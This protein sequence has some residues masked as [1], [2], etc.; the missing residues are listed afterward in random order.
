M[1]RELHDPTVVRQRL[2][3]EKECG[4][5]ASQNSN[6]VNNDTWNTRTR[7]NLCNKLHVI[8]ILYCFTNSMNFDSSAIS[9][10][11]ICLKLYN[12]SVTIY[13]CEL[14]P[15]TFI[16]MFWFAVSDDVCFT[17]YFE[18]TLLTFNNLPIVLVYDRVIINKGSGYNTTDEVF[19][20]PKAGTYLF[21]W[22]SAHGDDHNCYLTLIQN[23]IN[24]GLYSN[25]NSK[26]A[27]FDSG[28]MS[29]ALE[30]AVGDKIWIWNINCKYLDG[31]VYM[32]FTGCKI[33]C[34]R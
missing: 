13:F 14:I 29:V 26:N 8:Y 9:L 23:G 28:S 19:T 4:T 12:S 32:S 25:S 7:G 27:L 30:L 10:K 2:R 16:V 20:A 1:Q 15:M 5:Q 22:N 6:E 24:V 34:N 17:A 18:S 21:I 33:W 3:S 31:G 11:P